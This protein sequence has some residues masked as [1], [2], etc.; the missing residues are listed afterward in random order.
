MRVTYRGS[1]TSD[2]ALDKSRIALATRLFVRSRTAEGMP[3]DEAIARSGAM[4]ARPIMLTAGA[5]MLGAWPITLN[6]IFSGL[7]WALV[8]GLVASTA[9]ILVVVLVAHFALESS[10]AQS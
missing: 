5:A 6:P 2:T 8:F 4:R 7:A 3:L 10:R 1:T 9:F